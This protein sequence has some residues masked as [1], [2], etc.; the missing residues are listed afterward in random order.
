M[1]IGI[2]NIDEHTT[3]QLHIINGT[4][5]VEQSYDEAT[6]ITYVLNPSTV[7]AFII[8]ALEDFCNRYTDEDIIVPKNNKECPF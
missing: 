8:P 1:K 7:S 6:G 3:L 4:A 2:K 5:Y